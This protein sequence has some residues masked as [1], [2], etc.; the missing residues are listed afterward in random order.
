MSGTRKPRVTSK[1]M[2]PVECEI[3]LE[4][5][6]GSDKDNAYNL[7]EYAANSAGTWQGNGVVEVMY[8]SDESTYTIRYT[9]PAISAQVR[10]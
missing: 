2:G 8:M 10:V 7:R 1:P 9:F 5:M 3:V 4:C 6:F